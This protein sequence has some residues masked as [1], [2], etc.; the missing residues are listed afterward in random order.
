MDDQV[1]CNLWRP[2]TAISICSSSGGGVTWTNPACAPGWAS[3]IATP[4]HPD[5]IAGHPAFSQAGAVVLANFFGTDQIGFTS[6]SQY[7]CNGGTVNFG[8]D[9]LVASCTLNGT[10]FNVSNP[11]D[12][13]AFSDGV[14]VNGSPLICPITETFDSFSAASLRAGRRSRQSGLWGDPYT[15]RGRG[16][17]DRRECHRRGC[18]SNAGLPEPVP[19][20]S[21]LP[22]FYRPVCHASQ[23]RFLAPVPPIHAVRPVQRLKDQPDMRLLG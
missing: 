19:E 9:G 5:Y 11:A 13:A 3:L 8:A 12:C 14:V 10:T 4:P 2:V 17:I 16:R 21:T 20:P 1:P 6:T 22:C 23:V 7:Y 18:S 15:F